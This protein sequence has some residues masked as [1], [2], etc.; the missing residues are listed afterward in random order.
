[1]APGGGPQIVVEAGPALVGLTEARVGTM[2]GVIDTETGTGTGTGTETETEVETGITGV[3]PTVIGTEGE[4]EAATV[5]IAEV[6]GT[7]AAT[8]ETATARECAGRGAEAE[9]EGATTRFYSL[10]KNYPY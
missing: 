4:I 5:T 9:T 6:E 2:A 10:C 1:M 3:G 8:A 7:T